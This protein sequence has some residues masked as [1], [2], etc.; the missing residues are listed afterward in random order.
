MC[1]HGLPF[2]III[3]FVTGCA[4]QATSAPTNSST[5]PL[6]QGSSF[7]Q[8][9]NTPSAYMDA[10][11]TGELVVANGCLRVD[12]KYGN[13]VLLW[14]PD[15]STHTEQGIIQVLDSTGQIV[16]GVGDWVEVGG[17]EVPTPTYLG[18]V[19][20]LPE[21][22]PGPYWLVGDYIKKSTNHKFHIKMKTVKQNLLSVTG[23][24]FFV[25]FA[26]ST[27]DC[28]RAQMAGLF[29]RTFNLP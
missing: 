27:T 23:D 21:N 28:T 12:D 9:I 3:L 18:L 2:M 6:S 20:P 4:S 10:L 29:V 26:A 1:K 25:E 15:F 7:P 19:D 8:L 11:I 16:A 14:P 24:S 22:C 17:G 13:N 5:S